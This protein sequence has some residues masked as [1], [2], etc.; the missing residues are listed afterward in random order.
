MTATS[1]IDLQNRIAL[2]LRGLYQAVDTGFQPQ[3]QEAIQRAINHLSSEM[4]WFNQSVAYKTITTT[5]TLTDYYSLPVDYL[6]IN[7]DPVIIDTVGNNRYRLSKVTDEEL[8]E[9]N[10][11][12]RRPRYYAIILIQGGINQLRIGP[13]PDKVY[14]MYINYT[15]KLPLLVNDADTNDWL[16]YAKHII[17]FIAEQELAIVLL[18]NRQLAADLQQFID[19]ELLLLRTKTLD[20]MSIESIIPNDL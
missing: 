18:R 19:K 13:I 14:S 3:I 17:R 20:Y 10:K 1:Y 9:I 15:R 5:G 4:F 8:D 16:E 11:K 2:D 12:K 6:S 7:S